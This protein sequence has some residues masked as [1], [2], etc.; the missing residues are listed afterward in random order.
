MKRYGS[1]REVMNGTARM[2]RGRLT[3]QNF[4][5]NKHGRIV[6]KKKYLHSK[7]KKTNPLL[8]LGYQKPK[9]SKNFGPN[10]INDNKKNQKNK[11]VKK[12]NSSSFINSIVSLFN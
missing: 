11:N 7:N 3:K 10:E 5:K 4:I 1:R 8:K 2:T 12:S 6:S 9:G